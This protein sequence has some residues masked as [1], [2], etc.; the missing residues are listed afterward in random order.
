MTQYMNDI[1]MLSKE[2]T[3]KKWGQTREDQTMN[4][5]LLAGC[6]TAA[7]LGVL[8]SAAQVEAQAPSLSLQRSLELAEQT[9]E[10]TSVNLKNYY[11]FSVMLTNSSKGQFWYLTY[12]ATTPSEFNEIF[13]K[14]YMDSSVELSGGPF[15]SNSGY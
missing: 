2:K 12:R 7:I 6:V 3:S 4:R 9:L 10:K 8:I 5:K 14:V 13:A 15:G 11:L 1:I